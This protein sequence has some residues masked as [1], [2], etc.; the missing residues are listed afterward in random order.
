MFASENLIYCTIHW[1]WCFHSSV[2]NG[3]T[4]QST[5]LTLE[6]R[7]RPLYSSILFNPFKNIHF[8]TTPNDRILLTTKKKSIDF[9]L[10]MLKMK[11][12]EELETPTFTTSIPIDIV[13]WDHPPMNSVVPHNPPR[14]QFHSICEYAVA[15]YNTTTSCLSK[16]LNF[17]NVTFYWIIL[18]ADLWINSFIYNIHS[19]YTHNNI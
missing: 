17:Q 18:N 5:Y 15:I 12:H 1:T 2:F 4:H 3:F 7:V 6:F 8:K 14:N 19:T 10:Q 11:K 9:S 16:T 13:D